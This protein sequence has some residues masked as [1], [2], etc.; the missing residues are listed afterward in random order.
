[1]SKLHFPRGT[2][3]LNTSISRRN[4]LRGSTAALA[5]PWL[6]QLVGVGS[7]GVGTANE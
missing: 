6:E 1:M 2:N 4:F 5:L 7:K 3:R